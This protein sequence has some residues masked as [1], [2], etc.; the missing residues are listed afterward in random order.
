MIGVYCKAGNLELLAKAPWKIGIVAFMAFPSTLKGV[1]VIEA[2]EALLKDGFFDMIEHHIIPIEVLRKVANMAEEAGVEL[3]GA[4]QPTILIQKFNINSLDEGERMRAVKRLKEEID[5]AHSVGINK[6]ALC[7]GP[8]PGSQKR[9]QAMKALRASLLEIC[10]HAKSYGITV[11]LE[12]FDREYDKKLLLGPTLETYKLIKELGE[13][14]TNLKLLW[15]LSHAPLLHEKPQILKNVK[16][17]LGH[18]HI[19]CAERTS[20]GLKDYHPGFYTP[21]AVN[22]V[23]DVI[24]LLKVL[25]EIRYEGGISFEV[26]PKEQENSLQVINTAKGVLYTAFQ[27]TIKECLKKIS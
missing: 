22:D 18:V 21:N 20:E 27:R 11:Y 6:V 19:G 16:N 5:V 14:T 17:V 4:L 7:S 15:D 26:K 25:L 23:N 24:E 1:D 10:E 9:E 12:N 2:T 13:E 8:D 3:A